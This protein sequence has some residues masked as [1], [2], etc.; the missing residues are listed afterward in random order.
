MTSVVEMLRETLR[1]ERRG[2]RP[3]QPCRDLELDWNSIS[4]KYGLDADK[5][6]ELISPILED[7]RGLASMVLALL[8]GE[9]EEEAKELYIQEHK[10]LEQRDRD[11]AGDWHSLDRGCKDHE[12]RH[13]SACSACTKYRTNRIK[14]FKTKYRC[15]GQMCEHGLLCCVFCS[16]YISSFSRCLCCQI[17][18]CS[19]A[20]KLIE[21]IQSESGLSESGRCGPVPSIFSGMTQRYSNDLQT[22][23]Q[24]SLHSMP[25]FT[26]VYEAHT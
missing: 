24:P 8:F 19:K 13:I 9:N 5:V 2:L 6:K 15:E 4:Q 12:S 23:S 21:V 17:C 14:N 26:N 20:L 11:T 1:E 25:S 7:T 10:W 18:K 22:R 3:N 16:R